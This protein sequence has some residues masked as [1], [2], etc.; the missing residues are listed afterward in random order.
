MNETAWRDIS[1]HDTCL[2]LDGDGSVGS[3]RGSAFWNG[4]DETWEWYVERVNKT[5]FSVLRSGRAVGAVAAME[6]A[7]LMRDGLLGIFPGDMPLFARA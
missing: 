3:L 7:E 5:G 2:S 1:G 6:A 4:T